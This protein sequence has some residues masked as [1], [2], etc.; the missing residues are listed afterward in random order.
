MAKDTDL[1]REEVKKRPTLI[2]RERVGVSVDECARLCVGEAAFI[3]ELMTYGKA[4]RECKWTSLPSIYNITDQATENLFV[5]VETFDV[6]ES[7][8]TKEL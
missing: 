1:D 2:L 7:K 5:N 3:C 4:N 6:F 8:K